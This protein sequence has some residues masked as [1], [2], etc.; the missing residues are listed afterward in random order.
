MSSTPRSLWPMLIRSAGIC[1][2]ATAHPSLLAQEDRSV[3][4]E[5]VRPDGT[6]VIDIL[7]D[8][9]DLYGPP[10]PMEDCSAEQEAAIISGEIIVCRRKQD[11]RAFRTTDPDSAET[12]YAEETAFRDDPRTPDFILDCHDQG[13]PF[14]CIV[15]GNA[16]PPA[17]IIDV[18][19]LPEAPPCS[20]A[21][22]IARGLPPLGNDTAASPTEEEL[23]LPEVPENPVP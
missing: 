19:A 17:L 14:G 2:I 6:T 21:D 23:G 12:R 8:A 9:D 1:F 13:Y 5:T 3:T 10:P 16:P 15:F 22:R 7:A 4:D 18:E 20:D 11:Q